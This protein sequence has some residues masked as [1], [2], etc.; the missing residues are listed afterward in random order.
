MRVLSLLLLAFSLMATPAWAQQEDAQAWGQLNIVLPVAPR[1]RVTLEQIARISDRQGGLYTTEFGGLVGWQVAK[2]VELGFGYRYVGFYNGNLAPDEN[3]LRQQVVLTSGRFAGRLRLD[4]RFSPV[5]PEIGFRVRPLLRYNLPLGPKRVALFA[6]HESFI[7]PNSTSWGQR[8]GYERMRN[9]VGLAFPIGDA[10][11]ADLGYLN[12]YRLPRGGA[13][14]Q[15]DHALN[16]QLT[17]NLGTLGV[18]G[19][20]D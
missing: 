8:A 4:E 2:G 18:A 15:M 1:L 16:V 7:L 10:V 17:V 13:R 11:T 14:A 3:R 6:S 20:H 12:Q 19:L 9:I 5:G